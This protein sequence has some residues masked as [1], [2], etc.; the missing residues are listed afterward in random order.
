[1][2]LIVD[3]INTKD[4]L[5]SQ[6]RGESIEKVLIEGLWL[7]PAVTAGFLKESYPITYTS[8]EFTLNGNMTANFKEIPDISCLKTFQKINTSFI[9]KDKVTAD[10]Y[11]RELSKS[12]AYEAKEG[13]GL[14][15]T[16]QEIDAIYRP[17]LQEIHNKILE[18]KT[19]SSSLK[20]SC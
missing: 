13:Q 18:Y 20:K 7:K 14:L 15:L 3:I 16:L 2:T 4:D 12:F 10:S 8:L 5:N 19:N 1:M 9:C 11:F 17:I 6:V